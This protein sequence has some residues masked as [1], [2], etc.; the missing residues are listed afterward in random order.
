MPKIIRLQGLRKDFGQIRA[1][2]RLDL[3]VE[4]GEVLGFLGPNGAGKTTTM[5]MITGYLMP[6]AGR[7]EVFGHDLEN[8]SIQARTSIGYLPEGSPLYPDM[9]V[10]AFLRFIADIR[11]LRGN[12][13]RTRL[14][15]AIGRLALEDVL[16]QPIDTLSK[17]FRRRVGLAQAILHDPPVLILDEPTDGLDP[18]QKHMVR[19]WLGELARTKSII[20]STHILEEIGAVCNRAA[21]I[22]G[23]KLIANATPTELQAM[24]RYHGALSLMVASDR[25]EALV[26]RLA[27]L[28]YIADIEQPTTQA[29]GRER[30]ILVPKTVVAAGQPHHAALHGLFDA[31]GALHG[32]DWPVSD[33]RVEAGQ[34]DD[35]F[36]R[37]TTIAPERGEAAQQDGVQL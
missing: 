15:Y 2:D 20:I 34:L 8:A 21:I 35:V 33:I 29:S 27:A 7:I 32:E 12:R 24:S 26:N 17:G 1:V 30:L 23:G 18:N 4:D 37:L 19:E 28:E 6:S 36:R 11:V 13:R 22:A 9:T 14:D 25:V 3:D 16:N 5:R 10:H 31:G